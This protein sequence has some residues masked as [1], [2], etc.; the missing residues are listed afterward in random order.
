MKNYARL[1][2]LLLLVLFALLLGTG[3]SV[4]P[5]KTLG[6]HPAPADAL[7][8]NFIDVGQGDATL[9]QSGGKNYL[10]DGGRYEAGPE[11]VDFLRSRGVQKLDGLVATHPDADHVG[12]LP[13]VLD[14]FDVSTVYLSG[15]T[16]GTSTFGTFLRSVRDEGARVVQSRAGMRMDWGGTDA[17]V[18]SPPPDSEGG[19]FPEPNDNSVSILLTRGTARILL[20]GDAEAPAERYMSLGPYTGPLTVMKVNH[21]GSNTSTTP[22]FLSRFRPSIAVISVGADNPYGHPTPQTLRRLKVAGAKVFRT[23][24]DGDVIVTVKDDDVEVAVTKP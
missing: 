5:G 6:E 23:D 16:K 9:I 10:I 24:E 21:H 11:V 2:C 3:C 15:D 20:S 17:T 14:A 8:V 4:A 1:R 19:L 22:L 18:I 12:G 7:V 13:Q